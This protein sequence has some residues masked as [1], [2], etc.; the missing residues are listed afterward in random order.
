MGFDDERGDLVFLHL[1]NRLMIGEKHLKGFHLPIEN[2]VLAHRRFDQAKRVYMSSY[3]DELLL[4]ILRTGMKVRR[5]DIVKRKMITSSTKEEFDWLKERCPDFSMAL[6]Q[7]DW[8]TERIRASVGMVFDG[9]DSWVALMKLKHYLYVDLSPYSQGSGLHNTFMRN[10]REALRVVLEV[11][12]RYLHTKYTLTRRRPA[13]GGVTIAFLGSD[14]AGKSTAIAEIRKWLSAYMDVRFFYLGSG[15]GNS[16]L[17]RVPVKL[18][19][20]LAKKVGLVK[21]SNNFSDSKLDEV[22]NDKLWWARRLWAYSLS[23]ER[24]RKLKKANRCRLRG[25]VVL[26]DRYPQDEFHGLCDGPKLNGNNG[27][28]VKK[29]R[30]CFRVARLCPPDLAIKLIVPPEVAVRRKPGDINVETSRSLTE[31]V[32]MIHFSDHTKSVEIDSAQAQATVWLEIKRAI[33][34]AIG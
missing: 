1:H 20:K 18:G 6:E 16:S 9:S 5:R 30:E 24:I 22:K 32:K 11:K 26:T 19:L 12:K 21:T 23:V 29:E 3:F 2:E 10:Y 25:F 28:V 4:L 34:D 17:L 13:T 15:D 8:L 31:R 27:L 14:G 7:V 33:W